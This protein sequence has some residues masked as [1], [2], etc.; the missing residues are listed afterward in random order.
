M[1]EH[2]PTMREH[3][4]TGDTLS[5]SWGILSALPGHP[6]MWILILSEILV[7]GGALIAFA[8]VRISEPEIFRQSQDHLDRLA[9]ALNTMILV[10]SGLCA[11]LAVNEIAHHKVLTARRWLMGASA[12]GVVFLVVKGFENATKIADGFTPTKNA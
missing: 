2:E 10:T 4:E 5:G 8:G 1:D 11:A 7:F 9:G 12:L 6:M 3:N